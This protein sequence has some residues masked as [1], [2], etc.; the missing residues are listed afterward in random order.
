M[1]Q[2]QALGESWQRKHQSRESPF[3]IGL[4]VK[5]WKQGWEIFALVSVFVLV[6]IFLGVVVKIGSANLWTVLAATLVVIVF[7]G[8]FLTLIPTR[9]QSCLVWD[10]F[11]RHHDSLVTELSI[12][13]ASTSLSDIISRAHR[14]LEKQRSEIRKQLRLYIFEKNEMAVPSLDEMNKLHIKVVNYW[15]FYN[16]CKY[17]GLLEETEVSVSVVDSP[18]A[19]FIIGRLS[20]GNL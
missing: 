9:N 1:T 11:K 10:E 8:S 5:R 14:R 2:I 4:R 20:R 6:M 7:V 13:S 15:R 17:L 18:S 19:H 12:Q 3:D 16:T